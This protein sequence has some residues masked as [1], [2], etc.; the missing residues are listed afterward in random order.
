MGGLGPPWKVLFGR[1]SNIKWHCS[2]YY[3]LKLK[4]LG[5]KNHL[6]SVPLSFQSLT[7]TSQMVKES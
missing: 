1:S 4:Q 6:L 2:C 7:I 3:L 5:G